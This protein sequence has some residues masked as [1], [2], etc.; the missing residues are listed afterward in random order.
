M[1]LVIVESNG[2][3]DKIQKI[4]G[5]NY[6]VMACFGHIIDLGKHDMSINFSNN[7]EPIYEVIG[8]KEDTIRK[9]TKAYNK[10]DD[11]LLATDMDREGEMIAWSLERE[12]GLKN[13]K[14]IMFTEI[15]KKGLTDAVKKPRKIDYNIV[16]AQKLR[17][18]LDRIIGY[19]ISP[20]LWKSI[21]GG[22]L[23]AG[24]VQS[25]VVRLIIEKE[26]EI[27]KFFNS[28]TDT[29]FKTAGEF[30]D[31]TKRIF[32]SQLYTTNKK[33]Q[34]KDDEK[35]IKSDSNN[36]SESDSDDESNSSS[37]SEDDE[38]KNGKLAKIKKVDD[39]KNV[40]K[41]IMKSTFK[42]SA[43]GEKD[44][45][46][47]P[48]APFTTSTLQQEASRKYGFTS[49]RTMNAA[50]H[51]YEA[52]HIT[53][54]RTDSVNLSDEA[55]KT[56]GE[57]IV[58]KYGKEYHKKMNYSSK[59]KNTQEAH[60]AVRPTE[61]KT[62]GISEDDKTKIGK[63]EIKLYSL[64]WRRA[65]ASQMSPAKFNIM[66]IQIDISKLDDY[67]FLTQIEK[68]IFLGFLAVYNLTNTENDEDDNETNNDDKVDTN[69]T[70]P[71]VGTVLNP[72]SVISTQDFKRP[73]V[74]YN[75]ATLVG[76]LDP[77]NLNI[78]RP[79]TYATIIEKIQK[80]NYVIKEDN[81]GKTKESLI[82]KWDGES[83]KIKETTTKV[84]LGKDKNKFVPTSL[85]ILV[86]DFLM[87][88]FPDIM[89]YK[90]TA[91]METHLDDVA[92]G[93]LKWNK[94][95]DKFYKTFQ[96]LIDNL[97]KTIKKKDMIDKHE[98]EL[99]IHPE[100]GMK[101]VAT[102]AKFGPIVK[103]AKEGENK[104]DIAPIKKPLTLEKVTLED[105]VKLFEFPKTLGKYEKKTVTLNRGKFGYYLKI[106]SDKD[107]PK[108]ALSINEEDIDDF[109]IDDAI[110]SI[111]EKNKKN[112]WSDKDAK[113]TY[114]VLEGQYG[115][116]I[117]VKLLKGKA[118]AKN[119]KLPDG[120]DLDKLTLEK[121]RE[122]MSNSYSK[123]SS[124]AKNQKINSKKVNNTDDDN[125]DKKPKKVAN[126]KPSPKASKKKIIVV[127]DD[128]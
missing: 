112:L 90:F 118:K 37:G 84:V 83:S 43:I 100:T 19:R 77:K 99:G 17:R 54:M 94:V 44:S 59:A 6:T 48:S 4:L 23:S 13:P 12:L 58:S 116:Y 66:S 27:T 107:A 55:L 3:V 96:P 34:E 11:I 128:D 101:I 117:S 124:N 46:R 9:I 64:I 15:T 87:E 102:I 7:F 119:Y 1:T 2:K 115:K 78:G 31:K 39:A 8:G 74:R 21:N 50:Q 42:I 14:R 62:A 24:R 76:K 110:T 22:G 38:L 20:L 57:F 125:T 61:P 92:E 106:G 33:Y 16:D 25:V 80:A 113:Q 69:V 36:D 73:P 103:M 67:Y 95:L 70:I 121:V 81:A 75:E 41:Y 104:W 127:E 60:E 93:K 52:G 126:K 88:N 91:T 85:G 45:I 5:N 28:D 122:I 26:D 30:V 71:K 51:L 56:I 82:M 63:D 114:V 98:K 97:D 29:F 18:V 105:A 108:V 120:I 40:M 79:S 89:D 47:K 53:Y 86:N 111:E 10:S 109:D 65:I 68:N 35:L 32:K 72:K 123:S 49:K